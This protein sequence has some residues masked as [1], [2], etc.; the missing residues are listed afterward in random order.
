L[1]AVFEICEQAKKF[2]NKKVTLTYKKI[3]VSDCQSA[4]P[5]GKTRKEMLIVKM[6]AIR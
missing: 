5:C 6:K 2:Q 1:G 3:R 4:E